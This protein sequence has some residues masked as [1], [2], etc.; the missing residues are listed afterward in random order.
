VSTPLWDGEGIDPWLPQRLA[1]ESAITRAERRMYNSWWG[2]FSDWLVSVKRQVT[3]GPLDPHAVFATAPLWAEKM[4]AF[5]AGP[6]RDTVGL[7]FKSL[8]GAEYRFDARPAVTNYLAEV[9]NRMVR[10]PE[11]VFDTIASTVARGAG[12]GDSIRTVAARIDDILT[13]GATDT[14]AGRAVT[15]AR[16]ETIGALNG[17]R[18][19]AFTAVAELLGGGFEQMWLAT[20]DRRTRPEHA[21][22][23][24]QRVP[25]GEAFDVGGEALEQPGDPAGS[26][27]NVINCRCTTLLMRVGET[28]DLSD[29]GWKT[30]DDE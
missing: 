11:V 19:D 22:A 4:Q 20:I 25:V 5:V 14:W 3:S 28:Q 1:A 26:G 16:T 29:R 2:S 10:T 23:D 17:G 30:F 9:T 15:V 21:E 8:F 27:W 13:A 18:S 7:A 24:G 6:V 12:N